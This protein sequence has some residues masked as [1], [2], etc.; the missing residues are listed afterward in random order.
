MKLITI[1][2]LFVSLFSCSLERKDKGAA[3]SLRTLLPKQDTTMQFDHFIFIDSTETYYL[4]EAQISFKDIAVKIKELK[5]A[6]SNMKIQ[7]EV[8]KNVK[9]DRLLVIMDACKKEDVEL[10]LKSR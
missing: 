9:M 4:D 1:L 2:L 5:A 3:N 8:D 7:L 6:K 10:K